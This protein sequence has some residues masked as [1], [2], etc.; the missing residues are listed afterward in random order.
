MSIYTGQSHQLA[1]DGEEL[2]CAYETGDDNN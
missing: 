1:T 2:S